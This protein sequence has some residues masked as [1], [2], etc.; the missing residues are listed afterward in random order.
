MATVIILSS[1]QANQVRGPSGEA[2]TLATLQ[3][4]ALLDGT[5]YLGVETLSDANFAEHHALLAGLPQ[6]DFSS[7]QALIPPSP[8]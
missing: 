5:F 8:G 1:A 4:I 3:P 7:I 2:S 6:V